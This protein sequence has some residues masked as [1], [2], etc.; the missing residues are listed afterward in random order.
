MEEALE[1]QRDTAAVGSEEN[2]NS[3]S[4]LGTVAP[5]RNLS[6]IFYCLQSTGYSQLTKSILG[7][8]L[9]TIIKGRMID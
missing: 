4:C 6:S 5:E 7:W 1:L 3:R 2:G 9:C 8:W